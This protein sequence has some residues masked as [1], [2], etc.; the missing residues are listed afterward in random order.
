VV[1]WNAYFISCHNKMFSLQNK[2]ITLQT[3]QHAL[4]KHKS[5][6]SWGTP[7]ETP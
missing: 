2:M 6:S 4:R 3:T 1:R 5:S 7:L